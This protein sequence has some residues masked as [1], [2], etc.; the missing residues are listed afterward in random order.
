MTLELQ[1]TR[2]G[3]LRAEYDRPQKAT[4]TRSIFI[5]L[6]AVVVGVALVLWNPLIP[7]AQAAVTYVK[8]QTTTCKLQTDNPHATYSQTGQRVV[9]AKA[10]FGLCGN[11]AQPSQVASL[12]HIVELQKCTHM[13][14]GCLW[15]TVA[16]NNATIY[17]GNA[18]ETTRQASKSCVTG[19][20]RLYAKITVYGVGSGVA[21]TSNATGS[22][23]VT[24]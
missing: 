18:P 10:K 20:Y 23:S 21:S 3:E 11:G 1:D 16:T 8:V 4:R 14:Y 2:P 17:G 7:A 12:V 15:S 19:H 9:N 5:A 22:V 13:S 6:S 24:C